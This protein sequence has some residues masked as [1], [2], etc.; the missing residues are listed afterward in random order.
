MADNSQQILDDVLRQQREH[1]EQEISEQD[2]FEIFCAEQILKDFDLSYDEIQNGIVD[3]E[4]DGGVDS[5]YAFVNGELLYEDFDTSPFKKDVQIELHII[6]SKT[7]GGFSEVPVNRLI[8]VSRN[9]LRLD[10]DYGQLPQYN[11]SV[12]A[13][14]DNFRTSYRNLA[15]RFPGLRI[16]YYYASKKADAHIHSNLQLKADELAN[17]AQELFQGSDVSVEF[18]GA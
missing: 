16:R 2:H 13:A 6:Q 14:I 7:S 5:V 3:G 8:S 17:V 10:A 12:K 4:H 11:A 15:S 9:L 18:L 1:L